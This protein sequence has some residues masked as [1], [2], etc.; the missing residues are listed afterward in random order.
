MPEP[1]K[2]LRYYEKD[3]IDL[4]IDQ[5]IQVESPTRKDLNKVVVASQVQSQIDRY[6]AAALNMSYDD[7]VG[8]THNSKRLGDLMSAAGDKRPSQWCDAHAIVSG[9]HPLAAPHRAVLAW[10][11]VR[12]DD[13]YN[14]VWLPRCTKYRSL[15]P[16][17]LRNAIPHSR[18]HTN[19]YYGWLTE[20]INMDQ[21]QSID[22]LIHALK[23][24][25][26]RLEKGHLRKGIV[27]T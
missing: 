11:K 15:M 21:I 5:F 22:E 9:G 26:L 25:R 7:F 19:A 13:P 20:I 2:K 24:V 6:R 3:R 8:E 16:E 18:V 10:F 23:M 12:I 14:G 1:E 27:R 17:H 4:A